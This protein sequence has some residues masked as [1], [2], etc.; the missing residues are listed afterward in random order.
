MYLVIPLKKIL[1]I[2]HLELTKKKEVKKIKF[3]IWFLI[4]QMKEKLD[5]YFQ[6]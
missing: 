1:L 5:L 3:N 2:S 4:Q 6:S